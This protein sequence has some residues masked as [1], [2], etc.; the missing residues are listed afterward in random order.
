MIQRKTG[1]VS[2]HVL[3]TDGRERRYHQDQIRLRTVEV[4][5]P[6]RSVK[7]VDLVIPTSPEVATLTITSSNTTESSP[8]TAGAGPTSTA[9]A[10][11][12]S[13]PPVVS[14]P[15]ATTTAPEPTKKTY[16]K[17]NRIPRDRY[18]PTW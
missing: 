17:R 16:P 13:L 9:T 10:V 8:T 4:Q 3:L 18:E 6:D 5:V 12:E 1:L 15:G 11:P 7:L 2:F 14:D